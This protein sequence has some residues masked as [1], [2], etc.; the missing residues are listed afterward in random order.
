MG[1][2]VFSTF[3][4][5]WYYDVAKYGPLRLLIFLEGRPIFSICPVG[6]I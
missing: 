1:I 5:D 4:F 2:L 3:F 6:T